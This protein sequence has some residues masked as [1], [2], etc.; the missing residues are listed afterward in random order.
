MRSVGN[1]VVDERVTFFEFENFAETKAGAVAV[2]TVQPYPMG[3]PEA[4]FTQVPEASEPLCW[5][6][7]NPENDFPTRITYDVR[8]AGRLRVRLTDPH[9]GSDQVEDMLFERAP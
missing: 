8:E 3:R 6:F 2:W 9:H 1:L 4:V 5:A 7:D